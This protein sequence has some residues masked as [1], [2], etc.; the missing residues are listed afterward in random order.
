ML[1]AA[2]GLPGGSRQEVYQ[3]FLR[4]FSIYSVNP[5]TE[6]SMTKIFTNVLNT[7]LKV[8][9]SNAEHKIVEHFYGVTNKPTLWS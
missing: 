6:D 5:F 8:G 2:M 9:H 4:H 1:L 7:S 3:R